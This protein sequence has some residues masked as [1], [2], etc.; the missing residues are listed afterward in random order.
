[1]LY[2]II[3]IMFKSVVLSSDDLPTMWRDEK[4][5]EKEQKVRY[6]C[7]VFLLFF[8]FQKKILLKKY[9]NMEQ[10]KERWKEMEERES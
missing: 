9:K 3:L 5:D 4:E 7:I 6:E 10:G 2:I 8:H 1:M